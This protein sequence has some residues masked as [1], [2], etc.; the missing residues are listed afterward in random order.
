MPGVT[1]VCDVQA[2][3]RYCVWAF[4]ESD[5]RTFRNVIA[6]GEHESLADA[7]ASFDRLSRIYRRVELRQVQAITTITVLRSTEGEE[8]E[9]QARMAEGK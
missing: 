2:N 1:G 3:V 8:A 9:R 4:S 5:D 6:G 7:I